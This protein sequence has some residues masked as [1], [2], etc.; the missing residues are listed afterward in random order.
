MPDRI[1]Q[2][3]NVTSSVSGTNIVYDPAFK[4]PGTT[5]LINITQDDASQGDYYKITS[6]T[7]EGFT[8]TFYDSTGTAV[9]RTFDWL[10]K[11]WGRENVDFI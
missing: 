4:G 11:G 1:A 5:P 2:D 9:V 6:K 8:I 10:A 3:D 7:L